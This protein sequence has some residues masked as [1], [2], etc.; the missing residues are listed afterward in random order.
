MGKTL[1]RGPGRP[2][3][4]GAPDAAERMRAARER[5]RRAGF[6]LRQSWVNAAPQV[7]SDH[8][9]LDARS[10][11]L[12]C[13]IAR[14]L[15]ANPVLIDQARATLARW[16]SQVAQPA[17][18]YYLEWGRILEGSP[19]EIA[20]FLANM[21]EAATRLRQSSPFTNL[22]TPEERTRIYEAFR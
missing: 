2:P 21:G 22:L 16:R 8:Q 3:K 19:Q 17:P 13:L 7:Y 15:L 1:K 9:R 10:L 4:P 6:R 18:S 14:K 5:K 20:G 12:H 11:A